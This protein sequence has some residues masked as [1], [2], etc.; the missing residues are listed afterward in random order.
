MKIKNYGFFGGSAGG[1]VVGA[2][3]VGCAGV[4]AFSGVCCVPFMAWRVTLL[5]MPIIDCAAGIKGCVGVCC[6]RVTR[7]AGAALGLFDC[8]VFFGGA[9]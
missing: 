8:G 9:I 4:K 5:L 2:G 1:V 7:W 6:V 3:C